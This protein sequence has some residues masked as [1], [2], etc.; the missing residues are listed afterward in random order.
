MGR[1]GPWYGTHYQVRLLCSV[2]DV[3]A[4]LP[5]P[6]RGWFVE[7]QPG[8]FDPTL[9]L[10]L[11]YRE[12]LTMCAVDG[13]YGLMHQRWDATGGIAWEREIAY[14]EP[15]ATMLLRARTYLAQYEAQA[16][17]DSD[18]IAAILDGGSDVVE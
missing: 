15:A 16:T 8:P 18:V 11:G 12:G 5:Q 2:L 4:R 13:K 10:P 14:G 7:W 9:E 17:A 3:N 1:S 6:M